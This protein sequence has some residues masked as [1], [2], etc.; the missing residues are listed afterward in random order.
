M[1]KVRKNVISKI[2]VC[3]LVL[4]ILT[5]LG[6]NVVLGNDSGGSSGE[7][8]GGGGDSGL[9]SS[10]SC[11]YDNAPSYGVRLS[12]VWW[13]SGTRVGNTHSIDVFSSTE[14]TSRIKQF[15]TAYVLRGDNSSKYNRVD[16]LTQQIT[17][18][19]SNP[20][21]DKTNWG[22]I[23][24][25]SSGDLEWNGST[26]EFNY[27]S[28]EN[29][30][31]YSR[32]VD[33]LYTT[34]Q[35]EVDTYKTSKN[36]DDL[37]ITSALFRAFG[38][39]Y[40]NYT[41]DEL[42]KMHIA[43]E[44]VVTFVIRGTS[45]TGNNW[46]LFYGTITQVAYAFQRKECTNENGKWIMSNSL[47]KKFGLVLY[48]PENC[49]TASDKK[50]C[51]LDGWK[52]GDSK[53]SVSN[54]E[55]RLA[56]TNKSE[57]YSVGIGFL[58]L[59]A[60]AIP[61]DDCETVVAYVNDL[62][63]NDKLAQDEYDNYILQ[64]KN[65]TFELKNE[66]ENMIY[67]IKE[68][69]EFEF[70][71]K[72]N[73]DK[74]NEG[75]AACANR[76][77]VSLDCEAAINYINSNY[78]R[79]TQAYHNAV[80]QVEAGT[81]SYEEYD[82]TTVTIDKA[83]SYNMLDKKVYTRNGGVAQCNDIIMNVCAG[84]D[85]AVVNIDEC[86]TG[87]TFFGD[88]NDENLWLVCEIAYTKDG[89]NYS[90]DN[91]GHEAVETT[92]GGIVGNAEYC[93]VFCYEEFETAFPTHVY[94]VKAGQTFTWGTSDGKFGTVR[95]RKKCSNQ[96]YVKGQ[97]GYRFEE[98][99]E[100]YKENEEEMI[101]HFMKNGAYESMISGITS[102]SS[103]YNTCDYRCSTCHR[104][105]GSSY[106]CNC[107]Y[108]GCP[109][110]RATA[111][112]SGTSESYSH[113]A[114]IGSVTGSVSTQTYSVSGYMDSASARAAAEAGL[115]SKLQSLAASEEA[116]YSQK[117]N[118]E[119]ELIEKIEQ[120][121]NNIKYVHKATIQ[122]TFKEPVNSVYGANSRSFEFNDDF[123][124]EGNFNE[125]NVNTSKCTRK[126]IYKYSC[127]GYA[128]GVTCTPTA[129]QVWDCTVVT[130][131]IS[132]NY[133][134]KYPVEEFQW[135]SLKIDSTLLNEKDKGSE[136]DAFFYSIGFGL[137]TALSLT[138]GTYEL[139]TVVYD[140]GD[141]AEFSGGNP[142]YERPEDTHFDPI[143]LPVD[144]NVGSKKGFE[145]ICT[146]EVENE[147]FGYDCQYDSSGK[148][149]YSSPEYCDPT[150]DD[151]SDGSLLGIDI[152]YRLVTLLSDGD[153]V[154][155]A[156]P[157]QDGNGR[158]PGGNWRLEDDTLH[159]ILDADVY[160][161]PAMYEIMLDV[162][163]I[164]KIRKDNQTYFN[165]GK[166]PYASYYDAN[167]NQ[168]VYCAEEGDQK[169]CASEF[170]SDLYNGSGLNYRLL[171]TCLPTG[172]TL[173]RAEEV[174]ENGC[175]THYT[176]PTINWTR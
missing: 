160:N 93:E 75:L 72:E 96:N 84:A 103:R 129:K 171:G 128:S 174:L 95:I 121:T 5:N 15:S 94:D 85:P 33:S 124:V 13:E 28:I 138:D 101:E 53:T 97:Q 145:Y 127:S 62:Y 133:T 73:Y 39:E 4:V 120:C 47:V 110:Y 68:P 154:N 158:D 92:N 49:K 16:M 130:W 41:E 29:S 125:S 20:A 172:N 140:L 60:L 25:L 80:D 113:S 61:K 104:K 78:R 26:I 105:D 114:Y 57:K 27:G 153:S 82:G 157:G 106:K 100:D 118:E 43:I 156:F 77:K 34:M 87:K 123:I 14:S 146:Y 131:D 23:P 54:D 59:G 76:E 42:K 176:Y 164:Q 56:L 139:K 115:K 3:L 155:K 19:T 112:S 166:D 11:Q 1:L 119:A 142:Q 21:L 7:N 161:D 9:C 51:V 70:L 135:Y 152:T 8:S 71:V 32:F 79:G 159:D 31:D 48:S 18:Q 149:I 144:T 81:F 136:D 109:R 83:Y 132:G 173:E 86:E 12:L 98:W 102:S 126:T 65:G 147:V 37:K 58:W 111:R 22:S 162:N 24:K 168:K 134:Y 67:S 10:C 148:L 90:S 69:Q 74:Y 52:P 38:T 46:G 2:S 64:I 143:G 141:D 35:K 163:A 175:E 36:D 63:K 30:I 99:E 17:D 150:K 170:I 122:F 6:I 88:I 151:D 40:F 107:G 169:Y 55:K 91:T 137:P 66:S 89:K 165:S 45:N 50:Y 116:K 108:R 117:K 44:P 167:N